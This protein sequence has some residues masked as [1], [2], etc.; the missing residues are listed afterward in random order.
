MCY[1]VYMAA[2]ILK[3]YFQAHPIVVVSLAP[4]ADIIDSRDATGRVAKW[5]IEIANHG[6]QYEP[7][8]A[9]KSHAL[10]DFLVDWAETQYMPPVPGSDFWRMHFDGSKMKNGLGAAIVLTSPKGDRLH[11]V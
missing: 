11:Y 6:I 4:L 1:G 7:R 10:A 5:A 9:I 3:P 2:K 8:T